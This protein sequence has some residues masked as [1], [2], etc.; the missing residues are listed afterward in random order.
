MFALFRAKTS[1]LEMKGFWKAQS[2]KNKNVRI[3]ICFPG[4]GGIETHH[5]HA[6]N[7]WDLGKND[8]N[9]YRGWELP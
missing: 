1:H 7:F 5:Y 2:L 8:G 9:F 6:G 3:V 4:D